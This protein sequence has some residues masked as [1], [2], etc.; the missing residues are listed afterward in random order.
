[1]I[2]KSWTLLQLFDYNGNLSIGKHKIPL[3][4]RKFDVKTLYK[5]GVPVYV[6]T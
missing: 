3:Y 6:D 1:M 4:S 5:E 2:P